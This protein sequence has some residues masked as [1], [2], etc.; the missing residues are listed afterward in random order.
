MS[1][2]EDKLSKSSGFCKWTV[3]WWRPSSLVPVQAGVEGEEGASGFPSH[4]NITISSIQNK[5]VELLWKRDL[6]VVTGQQNFN[7]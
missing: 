6:L 3:S 7:L 4:S 5:I 1:L 2:S